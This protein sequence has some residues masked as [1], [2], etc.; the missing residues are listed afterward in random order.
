MMK[1]MIDDYEVEVSARRAWS[2][3]ENEDTEY[4]L[5]ELSIFLSDAATQ[6]ASH[7]YEVLADSADRMSHDIYVALKGAGAYDRESA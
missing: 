7:G 3:D 5:N 2:D 4:F 6:Y 1:L